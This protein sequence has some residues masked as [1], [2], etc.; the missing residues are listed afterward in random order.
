MM[1]AKVLSLS[2]SEAAKIAFALVHAGLVATGAARHSIAI[3]TTQYSSHTKT[4]LVNHVT[5]DMVLL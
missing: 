3:V 5:G 2:R 1:T 4:K